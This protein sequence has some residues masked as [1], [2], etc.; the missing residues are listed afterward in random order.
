MTVEEVNANL[1]QHGC[2]DAGFVWC[3]NRTSAEVWATTD[4]GIATG[5][6]WWAAKNADTPGWATSDEV[7]QVLATILSVAEKYLVSYVDL[8]RSELLENPNPPS[9][10][11]RLEYLNLQDNADPAARDS[12]CVEI[13]PT[14]KGLEHP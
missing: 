8:L 6:F 10:T 9:F 5:L 12:W 13:L 1:I 4:P 7:K 3:K 11:A 14:I 2:C